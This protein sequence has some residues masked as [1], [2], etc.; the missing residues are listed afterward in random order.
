[1]KGRAIRQINEVKH[2]KTNRDK[3]SKQKIIPIFHTTG[4]NGSNSDPI[5]KNDR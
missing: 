4:H 5:D 2:N 1:M 3:D